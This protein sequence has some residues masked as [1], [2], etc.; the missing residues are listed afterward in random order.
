METELSERLSLS[1]GGDGGGKLLLSS[2]GGVAA[3]VACRVS[4]ALGGSTITLVQISVGM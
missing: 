1:R 3:A 2:L 4:L